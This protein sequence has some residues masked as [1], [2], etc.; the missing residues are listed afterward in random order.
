MNTHKTTVFLLLIALT[1]SSEVY[2]R[3]ENNI[4]PEAKCLDG[5]T[6]KVFVH[7][8]SAPDRILIYLF[9]NT[10]CMTGNTHEDNMNNCVKLSKS[11]FGS[12]KFMPETMDPTGLGMLDMHE[13]TN[14][15]ST[16]TKILIPNCDG[17]HYQGYNK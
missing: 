4:D 14:K 7:Q 6:P 3:L 16:W 10:S 8:G 17:T 11:R 2:Q 1:L 5:S 15:F 12:S 9:G 13:Q